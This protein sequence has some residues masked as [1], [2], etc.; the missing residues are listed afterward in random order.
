MGQASTRIFLVFFK[1]V[2]LLSLY[3]FQKNGQRVWVG[4]VWQSQFFFGG[5]GERDFRI[6]EQVER[7]GKNSRVLTGLPLSV[8]V[9]TLDIR[10]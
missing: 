4:G 5:G 3:M 8:Q 2:F 10:F 7:K 9:P 6:F 1:G